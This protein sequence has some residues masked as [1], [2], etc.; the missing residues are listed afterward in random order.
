MLEQ[1]WVSM[2]EQRRMLGSETDQ[3]ESMSGQ[4][5]VSKEI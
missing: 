2:L 1:W 5:M 3:W 4:R